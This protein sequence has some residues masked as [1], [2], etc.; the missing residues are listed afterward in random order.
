LFIQELQLISSTGFFV[1]W[2]IESHVGGGGV[3]AEGKKIFV[4]LPAM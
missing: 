3:D 1:P 2:L 4:F